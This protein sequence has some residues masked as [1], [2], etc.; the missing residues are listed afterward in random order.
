V[1]SPCQQRVVDQGGG[2]LIRGVSQPNSPAFTYIKR[3]LKYMTA[4]D[5]CSPGRP[6][7]FMRGT[8]SR[9]LIECRNRRY[10]DQ[11]VSWEC[12][13]CQWCV[14]RRRFWLGE[15][16]PALRTRPPPPPPGGA[17]RMRSGASPLPQNRACETQVD[18]FRTRSVLNRFEYV[19]CFS[20][21]PIQ[22]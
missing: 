18:V 4:S 22:V 13:I 17:I 3:S 9:E 5:R 19:E 14:L 2:Q 6:R 12:E 7:T 16:F 21:S 11:C 15:A 1:G 20:R 8:I 10:F